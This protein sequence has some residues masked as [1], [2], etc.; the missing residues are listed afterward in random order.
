[1]P[2]AGPQHF[3]EDDRPARPIG[4]GGLAV[5]ALLS[6]L[7]ALAAV[8]AVD[9]PPEKLRLVELLVGALAV[10]SLQAGNFFFGSS[11]GSKEKTEMLRQLAALSGRSG[12]AG[13][14]AP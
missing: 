11:S 2:P 3:P 10:V 6:T 7:A 8:L 5:F 9:I 13:G 1:M 14:G 4:S 12:Q